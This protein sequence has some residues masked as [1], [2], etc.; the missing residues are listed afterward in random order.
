VDH[1]LFFES[2]A[3]GCAAGAL[4]V[5]ALRAARV[6]KAPWGLILLVCL[7]LGCA[8]WYCLHLAASISASV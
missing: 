6:V 5:L 8:A 1:I 4:A 3:L 2:C 7:A